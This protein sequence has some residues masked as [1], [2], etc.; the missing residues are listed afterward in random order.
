MAEGIINIYQRTLNDRHPNAILAIR[1]ADITAVAGA[2]DTMAM[3]LMQA[4]EAGEAKKI[5]TSS[6]N[7]RFADTTQCGAGNLALG[8][9]DEMIGAERFAANLQRA[10]GPGD[11]HGVHAA[12]GDLIVALEQIRSTYRVGAPYLEPDEF[13][14]YD[15]TITLLAPLDRAT[16]PGV[17]WRASIYREMEGESAIWTPM[18][19]TSVTLG[20][21]FAYVKEGKWD[22]F[23]DLWYTEPMTPTV[24]QWCNYTPPSL[25]ISDTVESMLLDVDAITQTDLQLTWSEPP[26]TPVVDYLIHARQPGDISW[27][28]L[29]SLPTSETGYKL[30]VDPDGKHRFIVIAI[31]IDGTVVAKSDTVDWE[32]ESPPQQIY[33]PIVAR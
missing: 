28:Q 18:P 24:G 2:V 33:L 3:T 9:P 27:T 6:V 14:D 10:F 13:W 21:S 12:A 23:I 22:E 19:G 30:A 31:D 29:A 25:V 32:G 16:R 26:G 20:S 1:S 7:S 4:V 17:A 11:A 15:D 8:P 5:G